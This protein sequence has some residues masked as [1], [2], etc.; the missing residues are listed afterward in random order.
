LE[1]KFTLSKPVRKLVNQLLVIESHSRN[2]NLGGYSWVC[3]DFLSIYIVHCIFWNQGTLRGG[4]NQCSTL[5]TL[6]TSSL[7]HFK[8][9]GIMCLNLHRQEPPS[10]LDI[11]IRLRV[12]GYTDT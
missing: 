1:I 8:H 5:L 11:S 2:G 6:L 9:V 12:T 3:N 4:V 7:I 10:S